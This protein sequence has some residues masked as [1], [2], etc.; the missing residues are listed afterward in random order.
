MLGAGIYVLPTGLVAASVTYHRSVDAA[1]EVPIC[2]LDMT[3]TAGTAQYVS[4]PTAR[5][6]PLSRG[7]DLSAR[8]ERR[9]H[10]AF[11]PS[12]NPAVTFHVGASDR[13][14]RQRRSTIGRLERADSISMAPCTSQLAM[15]QV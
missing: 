2:R 12:I 7:H 4:C 1:D 10:L 5:T 13:T 14:R 6:A 11:G 8:V 3:S 15:A 9:Q